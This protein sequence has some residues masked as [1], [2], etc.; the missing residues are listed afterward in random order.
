M[1]H[2]IPLKWT[3]RMHNANR[4]KKTMESNGISITFINGSSIV[5][6]SS[7]TPNCS[8]NAARPLYALFHWF[9]LPCP[10]ITD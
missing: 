9:R 6:E 2:L 3:M 5:T 7:W 4:G 8:P 1:L 10:W